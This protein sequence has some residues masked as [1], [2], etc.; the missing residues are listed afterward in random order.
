MELRCYRIF[1]LLEFLAYFGFTISFANSEGPLPEYLISEANSRVSSIDRTKNWAYTG[2][3]IGIGIC[4]FL[5]MPNFLFL[6]SLGVASRYSGIS[7]R[8]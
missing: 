8:R 4:L 5:G 6:T 1:I 2:L 3:K 7:H